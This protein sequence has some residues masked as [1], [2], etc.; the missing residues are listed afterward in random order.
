MVGDPAGTLISVRRGADGALEESSW[1]DG[2]VASV[3]TMAVAADRKTA[4]VTVAN[5]RYDTTTTYVVVK[6]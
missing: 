1:R 6:Q 3:M 2:K 4:K 5:K